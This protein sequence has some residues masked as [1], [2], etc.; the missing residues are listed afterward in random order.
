LAGRP[1]SFDHVLRDDRLRNLKSKLEQ[2]A[3]DARRAPKRVVAAHLLDQRTQS[4]QQGRRYQRH[5]LD[6][7]G[8]LK[9]E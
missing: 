6:T 9:P 7:R 5:L 2:F 8:G 1:A 4:E 3:V